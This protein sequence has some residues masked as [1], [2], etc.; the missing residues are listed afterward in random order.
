MKIKYLIFL[1]GLLTNLQSISQ[2]DTLNNQL[3]CIP[4]RIA[5]QIAIDLEHYDLLVVE[6]D[7]LKLSVKE[8]TEIISLHEY[9][10]NAKDVQIN[11]LTDETILLNQKKSLMEL[12]LEQK[13][14]QI[15]NLKNQRNI[16]GG[17]AGG[18][19]L[20]LLLLL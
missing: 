13:D 20:L 15:G 19:I 1:I 10:S 18:L 12:E 17:T 16:A 14:Q 9:N 5:Q 6:N 4:S 11:N 3:V 7:S 8:Y 2:T